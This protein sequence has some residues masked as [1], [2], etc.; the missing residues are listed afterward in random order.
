MIGDTTG[1]LLAAGLG[2]ETFGAGAGCTPGGEGFVAGAGCTL[3]EDFGP[4][5]ECAPAF[6]VAGGVAASMVNVNAKSETISWL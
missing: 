6:G 4:N 2:G 5:S 1:P 3:S